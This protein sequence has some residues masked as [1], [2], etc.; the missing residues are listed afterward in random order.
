MITLVAGP[1]DASKLHSDD[2]IVLGDEQ[3]LSDGAVQK[4]RIL[5]NSGMVG[6][7]DLDDN[8]AQEGVLGRVVQ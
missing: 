8:L 4:I 5:G 1:S 6:R 3:E 7:A 2:E